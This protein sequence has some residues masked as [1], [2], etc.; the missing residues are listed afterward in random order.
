MLQFEGVCSDMLGLL[1]LASVYDE[2][3]MC[4]DLV[5]SIKMFW[6]GAGTYHNMAIS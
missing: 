4:S 6:Q 5:F 1:N 3:F 2:K